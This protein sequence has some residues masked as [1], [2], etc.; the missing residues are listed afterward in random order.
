MYTY[1]YIYIHMP[2]KFLSSNPE[3]RKIRTVASRLAS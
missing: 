2:L 3:T 1:I